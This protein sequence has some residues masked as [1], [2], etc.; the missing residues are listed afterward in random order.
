MPSKGQIF[1]KVY[2]EDLCEKP[3]GLTSSLYRGLA[4]HEI[5]RYQRCLE[6]LPDIGERI[7]DV[8]CG[9]GLLLA[10]CKDRFRGR[11]GVD[12]SDVQLKKTKSRLDGQGN[13]DSVHLSL[14]DADEGLP[15][16][17]SFFDTVSCI[18]ALCCTENPPNAL[19][20][21]HR[22]VKPNATF[23]MQVPNIAWVRNRFQL[24]FGGCPLQGG[25]YLG[26][27]WEALHSF[28]RSLIVSL[29]AKVGFQVE[30][31]T[32]SGVLANIRAWWGS[33]LGGDIVLSCKKRSEEVACPAQEKG[34]GLVP[35]PKP[36]NRP[37]ILEILA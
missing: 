4:K 35:V 24:L 25:V 13:A 17:D 20:E 11:Y 32:C 28:N 8:C 3:K 23:V 30:A 14:C 37:Q 18:A 33:L 19:K 29:L 22:V 1:D 26:A 34:K 16:D 5:N 6:L 21:I 27:D 36:Q 2:G 7:L 9:D 15:F 31:I 10:L 12:V